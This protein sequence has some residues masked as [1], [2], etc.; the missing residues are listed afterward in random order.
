MSYYLTWAAGQ[1]YENDSP[2]AILWHPGR[3]RPRRRHGAGRLNEGPFERLLVRLD[4][5]VCQAGVVRK[6]ASMVRFG[7]VERNVTGSHQPTRTWK[8]GALAGPKKPCHSRFPTSPRPG[9][10]QIKQLSLYYLL[11]VLSD[12]LF[13]RSPVNSEGIESS[14]P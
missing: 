3:L 7:E 12:E 4:P 2:R 10:R 1:C 5:L 14:G 6:R 9:M 13:S 8:L 11:D